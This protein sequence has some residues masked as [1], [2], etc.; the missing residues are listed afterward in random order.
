MKCTHC[1]KGNAHKIRWVLIKSRAKHHSAAAKLADSTSAE[2]TEQKLK[3]W[4]VDG[5]AKP[6]GR[7]LAYLLASQPCLPTHVP[8]KSQVF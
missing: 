7:S 6:Y 8:V 2:L 1:P 5:F 4:L 3:T